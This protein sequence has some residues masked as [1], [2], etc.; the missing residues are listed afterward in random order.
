M[1]QLQNV[2]IS[3]LAAQNRFLCV[4]GLSEL[5]TESE[6]LKAEVRRDHVVLRDASF[7]S[8]ESTLLDLIKRMNA[9]TG[10]TILFIDGLDFVL[11]ANGGSS[12]DLNDMI[13]ELRQVRDSIIEAAWSLMAHVH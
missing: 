1:Q 3:K 11:A 7:K 5:F 4:D 12:V 6:A 9:S 8:I 13:M 10:K 2:D